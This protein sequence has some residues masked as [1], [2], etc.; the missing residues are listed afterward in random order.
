MIL[1]VALG[2]VLGVLFLRYWPAILALGLFAVAGTVVLAIAAL[3]L[4]WDA[5][6]EQVFQKTITLLFLAAAYVVGLLLA[7]VI[8][9]RSVLTV[10]EI[11]V[12][13]A[14][15]VFLVPTTSFFI[16]FIT[17]WA[18]EAGEPELPLFLLPLVGL[19]VW[20]WLKLSR[21]RRSRNAVF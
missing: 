15:A 3:F 20:L 10:Q 4:Y 21:L 14:I 19:W 6:N 16:W 18:T 8:A 12:L 7:K 1:D 11:G 5:S 13:L 2:L 9:Q 17:K